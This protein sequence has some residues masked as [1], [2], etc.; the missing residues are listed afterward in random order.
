MKFNSVCKSVRLV[1]ITKIQSKAGKD[2]Y[3]A[4]CTDTDSYEQ[5]KFLVNSQACDPAQLIAGVDYQL[6]LETDG[7]YSSIVLTPLK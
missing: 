5:G 7:R 6:K 2:L 1:S 3:F 4:T